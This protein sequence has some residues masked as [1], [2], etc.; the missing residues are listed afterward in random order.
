MGGAIDLATRDATTLSTKLSATTRGLSGGVDLRISDCIAI[1]LGGGFGSVDTEIGGDAA[2]MQANTSMV[3]AYGTARFLSDGFV[4]VVVGR[5]W[6]DYRTLR[7]VDRGDAFAT[8]QRN[9][10][11]YIG[12][13]AIGIQRQEGTVNWSFYGKFD[14]IGAELQ[15]YSEAGTNQ[16]E[17]L[18]FSGIDDQWISAGF[19]FRLQRGFKT[20][21]GH[22]MPRLGGE[23][24]YQSNRSD[25]QYVDYI[26]FGDQRTRSID[27]LQGSSDY[28][29]VFVGTEFALDH[30][31]NFDLEYNLNHQSGFDSSGARLQVS[32]SF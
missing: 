23:G 17:L 15:G 18:R 28:Y 3:A 6:P 2:G 14:Y 26:D 32:R 5:G 13:L 29:R 16:R 11:L 20:S 7:G 10:S 25:N 22:F 21:Y 30:G 24:G 4:D 8:G 12:A 31:L 27:V 9:G 19:G 1:G